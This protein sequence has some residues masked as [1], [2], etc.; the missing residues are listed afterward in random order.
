MVFRV[1]IA[2]RA[3]GAGGALLGGWSGGWRCRESSILEAARVNAGPMNS[4]CAQPTMG[5][6]AGSVDRG[7]ETGR[8]EEE[9]PC[10][11]GS[12]THWSQ[13]LEVKLERKLDFSRVVGSVD[14]TRDLSEE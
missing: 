5:Y 9:R 7:K 3:S 14:K 13:Q 6:S 12:S 2:V 11:A 8:A 4:R 10:S 1:G